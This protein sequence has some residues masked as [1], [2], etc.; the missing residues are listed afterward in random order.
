MSQSGMQNL[1]PDCDIFYILLFPI[2][3]YTGF[4]R[5]RIAVYVNNLDESYQLL[6]YNAV[7]ARAKELNMDIL[8]IQQET[9]S[10]ENE[11]QDPFPSRHFITVDGSIIL[12]TVVIN[13]PVENLTDQLKTIFGSMPIVSASSEIPSIPS[14]II[15][16]KSSMEHLMDHL[17]SVHHYHKFLY[18]G[19]PE[20]HRDNIIRENIFCQLLNDAQ[21]NDK[22]IS[23]DITHA[24]FNE[25]SGM[26]AV[27]E[28][29]KQHPDTPPDAIVCANDTTAIG[30]LKIINMQEDSRW[31]K[32]A[33]TGFDD[34]EKRRT[35]VTGLTTVR[36]P[37]DMMGSLS[38]EMLHKIL[39]GQKTPSVLRIDSTL[40]IRNSCGC[41]KTALHNITSSDMSNTEAVNNYIAHMQY[42]HLKSNLAQQ[43]VSFF[44]QEVNLASDISGVIASLRNFLGNVNINLFYFCLFKPIIAAI[45]EESMLVYKKEGNTEKNFEPYKKIFLKSFFDSE[46]FKCGSSSSHRIIHY[47]SSG[48]ERLGFVAYDADETNYPQM[49]SCAIFLAAAVK[50]IYT[51]A[52]EKDHSR[53]LEI[54]VKHRTQNLVDA[55]KKLQ[56]ES[57]KRIKVEA[58]VLKISEQERRRF[59]MDMHDDICQRLAGISMMCRGMAMQNPQLKDLSE[60]IDETLVRTRQYVHNSFPVELESLGMKQ[61]IEQLCCTTERQ[62]CGTLKVP[63]TWNVKGDI[64]LG[65]SA[66]IN[67][68]RIIQEAIHNAVK[69]A[70][71]SEIAVTVSQT[72]NA[73]DISIKDNGT[74][75]TAITSNGKK[76]SSR[77]HANY[78]IGIGLN[79]MKYRADQMGGTCHIA[80]S[81]K[82][83]TCVQLHIPL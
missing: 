53:L 75:N 35:D 2:F 17:L 52:E 44:G 31:R 1:I 60:L 72:E 67:V 64:K 27:Q 14:V 42:E 47:L 15:K 55:N 34:I 20:Q 50:R 25:Y 81:E 29:I 66:K 74:G 23:W 12:S 57:R 73:L 37:I 46:L 32:C 61:G 68:Y 51:L 39:T 70:H 18:I 9:F 38:V 22:T 6:F 16:T 48:T 3:C 33:V 49:C 7:R 45:P 58:E 36:Q 43:H 41:Q 5:M 54:E 11:R 56:T 76:M 78:S 59:S 80:S 40:V 13:S 62:G 28:Y 26:T 71:A 63:F 77:K 4:M 83:G 65:H 24:L 30:V 19:G 69:H 10:G 8:C 79:S 21:K 82:S